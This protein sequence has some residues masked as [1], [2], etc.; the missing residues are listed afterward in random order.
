MSELQTPQASADYEVAVRNDLGEIE[1]RIREVG[2]LLEGMD[3]FLRLLPRVRQSCAGWRKHLS[4]MGDQVAAELVDVT[5]AVTGNRPNP[6]S[7]SVDESH[8]AR[9]IELRK[10]A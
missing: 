2:V 5:E 1:R 3:D 7:E 6:I 9:V 8:A 10:E 4:E